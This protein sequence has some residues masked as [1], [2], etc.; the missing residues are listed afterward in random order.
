MVFVHMPPFGTDPDD[1]SFTTASLPYPVRKGFLDTCAVG[2][3]NVI[4]CGHVHHYRRQQY[5]GM[6]IVCAPGTAFVRNEPR[7]I[8]ERGVQR[9]GYLS[10]TLNGKESFHELIE[11]ELFINHDMSNW[12]PSTTKLPPR[13]LLMD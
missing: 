12:G 11:P 7:H 6:E 10:W 5:R 1:Q 8:V 9:S 13:A 4:A 2:G 3:V